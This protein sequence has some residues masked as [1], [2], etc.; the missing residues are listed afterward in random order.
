MKL[1][2]WKW[3]INVEIHWRRV[4]LCW[5]SDIQ[6]HSSR[7]IAILQPRFLLFFSFRKEKVFFFHFAA[8]PKKKEFVDFKSLKPKVFLE[9]L[10]THSARRYSCSTGWCLC[11]VLNVANLRTNTSKSVIVLEF[12]VGLAKILSTATSNI[13]LSFLYCNYLVTQGAQPSQ[14]NNTASTDP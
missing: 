2:K 4:L 7:G 9:K 5:W 3:I 12:R 1:G 11:A 8:L 6:G 13:S 14:D 10:S